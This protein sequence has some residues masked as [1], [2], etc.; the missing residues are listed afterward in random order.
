[1]YNIL[2]SWQLND[3]YYDIR[4]FKK[5]N[6]RIKKIGSCPA[7]LNNEEDAESLKALSN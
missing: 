5:M 2:L 4:I 6:E 3:I 7:L 1:M